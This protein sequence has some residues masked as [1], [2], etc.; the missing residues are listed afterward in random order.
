MYGNWEYDDDPSI[1]IEY[2]KI[3]D[4]FVNTH[5]QTGLKYIT[6]DVARFG[7]DKTVIRVWNGLISIAKFKIDKCRMDDLA[8]FIRKKQ[9]EFSVPNSNTI[10]DED[11]VGGGV[12]DILRCKGFVG[13]SRALIENGT[14]K[15]YSNLRSQCYFKLAAL[16]NENK[17]YLPNESITDREI[18]TQE[19]E[20]IKQ[21]DIEKDG[22]L[23]VIAKDDIKK[24]IGRS[25][26]ESDCLMMR[27]WFEIQPVFKGIKTQQS[28]EN[29]FIV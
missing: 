4:L 19:L 13:N 17:L 9:T 28:I 2:D 26:D 27:M 6:V 25:P 11:G 23:S 29:N 12:V 24:N 14:N 1:L 15:N 22:K 3:I 10:V 5:V 21:K 16:V 18:I 7:D 8:S 20:Q